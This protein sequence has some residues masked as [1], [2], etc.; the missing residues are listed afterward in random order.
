MNEIKIYERMNAL[1]HELITESI[2]TTSHSSSPF[3]TSHHAEIYIIWTEA[4]T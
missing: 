4:I 2:N 3:R 1:A